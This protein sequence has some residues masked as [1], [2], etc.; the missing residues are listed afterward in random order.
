M[1]NGGIQDI[2]LAYLLSAL[3]VYFITLPYLVPA[4]VILGQAHFL[5]TYR[6]QYRSKKYSPSAV[7]IYLL[8][9]F[10]LF[11]IAFNQPFYFTIFVS[12]FFL[13]HNFYDEMKLNKEENS[14]LKTFSVIPAILSLVLYGFYSVSIKSSLV[15]VFALLIF[16]SLPLLL[17][18]RNRN[19]SRYLLFSA[20]NCFLI[21]LL[22]ALDLVT[23]KYIWPWVIISHYQLWYIKMGKR[24]YTE[25]PEFFKNYLAEILLL[26]LAMFLLWS[27]SRQGFVPGV[28]YD[29]FFAPTAF[30]VWTLMHLAVTFRPLDY[31]PLMLRRVS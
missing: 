7:L 20:I 31:A 29:Y 21:N 26:N 19:E 14:W 16:S 11:F 30:Y 2:L 27:Y 15:T 23:I 24:F 13:F 22:L 28:I 6:Y 17:I 18:L 1:Q 25:N 9:L 10:A 8:A 4:F 12:V 5:M 3:L